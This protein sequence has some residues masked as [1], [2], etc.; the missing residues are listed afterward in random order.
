[1]D[2]LGG[3]GT[4]RLAQGNQN[5]LA[6][7]KI[8]LGHRPPPTPRLTRAYPPRTDRIALL[9]VQQLQMGQNNLAIP[10]RYPAESRLDRLV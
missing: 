10:H 4:G 5:K 9:D 8:P 1:M 6:L 7:P 2:G 3:A